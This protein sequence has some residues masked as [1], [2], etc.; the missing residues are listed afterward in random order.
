MVWKKSL[1]YSF[2]PLFHDIK[3]KRLVIHIALHYPIWCSCSE[4]N[5]LFRDSFFA[6]Q[7]STC[8]PN[9]PL[10]RAIWLHC[11]HVNIVLFI[12]VTFEGR[13]S[14]RTT[15]SWV[16][17]EL[18]YI[19]TSALS[20]I[21]RLCISSLPTKHWCVFTMLHGSDTKKKSCPHTTET[22][23]PNSIGPSPLS[24]QHLSFDSV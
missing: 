21:W 2:L 24:L 10:H 23:L 20:I 16:K 11:A 4:G 18:Q 9:T 14:F 22:T 7:M 13:V 5:L 1:K 15:R 12:A 3:T 6:C 17:V 8:D 19:W